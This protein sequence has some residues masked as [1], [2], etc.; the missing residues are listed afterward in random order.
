MNYNCNISYLYF[1]QQQGWQCSASA[2]VSIVGKD[3]KDVMEISIFFLMAKT[4]N[5]ALQ[6]LTSMNAFIEVPILTM[7]QLNLSGGSDLF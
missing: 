1:N 5:R 3:G 2:L 6:V 7:W 4:V